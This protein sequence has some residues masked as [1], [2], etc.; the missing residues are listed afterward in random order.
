[1]LALE[2]IRCFDFGQSFMNEVDGLYALARQRRIPFMPDSGKDGV[3]RSPAAGVGFFG[4]PIAQGLHAMP[5]FRGIASNRLNLHNLVTC[6]HLVYDI[7]YKPKND[8]RIKSRFISMKEVGLSMFGPA[9]CRRLQPQP[10]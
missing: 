1:M 2:S 10:P 7:R 6:V 3:Y 9:A 4:K 5:P 8:L